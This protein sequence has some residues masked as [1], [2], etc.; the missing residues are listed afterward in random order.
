MP[1]VSGVDPLTMVALTTACEA[2]FSYWA[3]RPVVSSAK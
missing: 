3:A 2:V 1:V